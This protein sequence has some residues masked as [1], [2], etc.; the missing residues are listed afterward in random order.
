MKKLIKLSIVLG[1]G[2]SMLTGCNVMT[3]FNKYYTITWKNYDGTVLEVDEKVLKGTTPT[4]DGIEP[5]KEKNEQFN[6]IFDGWDKEVVEATEDTEYIAKFKEETRVYTVIWKN[7]NG[8]VLEFDENVPYGTVPTFDSPAPTKDQTVE[9]V[10]S[11]KGW[12]PEVSEITGDITYQA[13]FEESARKYIVTWKNYDGTVLKA[14]E[15]EYGATPTYAG[16]TPTKER[17]VQNVYSFSGW[18]PS[19]Q[20][21]SGDAEYTATFDESVRK[22]TVTWKNYNGTILETSEVPYGEIPT[23]GGE[24][25]ER[26]GDNRFSYNFKGWSPAVEAVTND[27]TYIATFSSVIKKYTVTWKNYD[28]TILEVDEQVPYGTTPTYDG[29]R[30]AKPNSK[31]YKFTWTGWSPEV[32]AVTGNQEYIATFANGNGTFTFDKVDYEM[33]DGYELSD[34]QGSPWINSNLQGEIQK[35]KKPSLKDDFYTSIN[36]EDMLNGVGGCFDKADENVSRAMH[37]IFYG[38]EET[39]NSDVIKAF[40]S[41]VIEGDIDAVQ[42]YVDYFYLDNFLNSEELF[43]SVGSFLN[44][45]PADSGYQLVYDDGYF[46]STLNTLQFAWNYSSIGGLEQIS[47]YIYGMLDE[48]EGWLG[49]NTSSNDRN[50]IQTIENNMFFGKY[51]A[52]YDNSLSSV[53]TYTVN[54]V[55]WTSVKNALLDLGLTSSTQIKVGKGDK[56]AID[57]LFNDYAVNYHSVVEKMALARIMFGNR[58]LLGAEKYNELNQ[59]ISAIYGITDGVGF[60][61]EAYIYYYGDTAK[62]MTSACLNDIVNQSYLELESSAE[63]KANV[64][65]LIENILG[66]Y[67]GILSENDWMENSSK[68]NILRK[69]QHM[70]YE[71]CYP[72]YYTQIVEIEDSDLGTASL[73]T[74]LTRYYN[75]ITDTLVNKRVSAPDSDWLFYPPSTNNAFYSLGSNSFT[76]LNG[77]VSGFYR[78]DSIE[79]LYG[80]LGVVIGH[81]ITHA[82]DANGSQFNEYGQRDNL[83]TDADKTKFNN[84]VDKMIAFYNRINL[85]GDTYANGQKNNTEATADMGGM[86]VMLHLA[87]S[88]DNF[89]YDTF[90]RAFAN[91]WLRH[92]MSMDGIRGYLNDEH[93]VPYLRANITVAQFDEFVETYNIQPGDRMYIPESERVK[94]W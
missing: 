92:P 62:K 14:E 4:Y 34:I 9:N 10:Y 79:A 21:V 56:A 30:P 66:G 18:N 50:Y 47:D 3:L 52:M 61:N 54:S 28:G 41:K 19:V 93:P 60:P 42:D 81:E 15:V 69:L 26:I 71:S 36:Y 76:I 48:L 87:K 72:E 49:H 32:V 53:N 89:N 24:T 58:F 38:E 40:M 16:E 85:F 7:Y 35:I 46:T 1:I 82:F 94:I 2:T 68:Q 20:P 75:A 88:I 83:W 70:T 63:L 25:P 23:Y 55:P 22:Y 6:Y 27:V 84:K 90:F 5:S 64:A 13:E 12:S 80:S 59:Y 91:V 31:G 78:T 86:K 65:Q 57:L 67:Q 74:L 45:S 77:L 37:E 43:N 33:Q 8:N 73:Y 29:T 44:I 17:T 51:N 39:T 11:F